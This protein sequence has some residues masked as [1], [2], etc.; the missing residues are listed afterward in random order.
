MR[1]TCSAARSR[2]KPSS[3]RAALATMLSSR[4]VTL[5][6]LDSCDPIALTTTTCTA[7]QRGS[8]RPEEPSVAVQPVADACVEL[9]CRGNKGY[10]EAVPDADAKEAP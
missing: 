1:P 9:Q 10:S 7:W 2:R 4:S 6:G 8:A 3:C 5:M